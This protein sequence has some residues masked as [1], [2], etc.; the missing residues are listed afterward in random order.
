MSQKTEI[1]VLNRAGKE[2]ARIPFSAHDTVQNL[3]DAIAAQAGVSNERQ[4]LTLGPHTEG[5]PAAKRVVLNYDHRRL[6]E[7]PFAD[8]QYT[9]TLKDLG[10]QVSWTTVF[11][12][13]YGGPLLI[14]IINYALAH[15][16]KREL[17]GQQRLA[18]WLVV[19]HYSKREI[20]TLFVHIFSNGTMPLKNIFKNSFHY[21]ILCGVLISTE[22]FFFWKD[23]GYST[24]VQFGLAALFV[25]F[26]FL[27]LMCHITLRKLRSSSATEKGGHT[28]RGIPNG[29]G[30]GLV[31]CA[32]YL[33]ESYAWLTFAALTRCYTAYLFFFVSTGQML[34]WALKKHKNYRKE[35][36]GEDGKPKYPRGRKAMF[37]FVI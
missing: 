15:L 29:W 27:N 28:K 14:F 30:F 12:V 37:P 23:P 6:S 4:Y 16:L 20:E 11:L 21:W 19:L 3:K 34:I 18:F 26:E 25:L 10:P 5:T 8:N 31:S 22:L 35:F 7:F 1:K 9:V 13:E 36:N 2:K 17:V 24:Q 32:N 33:W